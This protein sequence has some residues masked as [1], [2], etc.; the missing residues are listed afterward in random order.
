MGSSNGNRSRLIISNIKNPKVPI[1][2][3]KKVFLNRKIHTCFGVSRVFVRMTFKGFNLK[4]CKNLFNLNRVSDLK[5][6]N[7]QKRWSNLLSERGW[8]NNKERW[9]ILLLFISQTFSTG[10]IGN[11]NHL[12]V[13][14]I[15]L[16]TH[17]SLFCFDETWSSNIVS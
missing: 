10:K 12:S 6:V 4:F 17:S 11:N 16:S 2:K 8:E 9:K 13:I 5:W 15:S 14:V 1:P 7:T 3:F